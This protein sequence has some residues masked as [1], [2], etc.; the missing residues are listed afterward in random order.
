MKRVVISV[1]GSIVAPNG[2]DVSYVKKLKE[3]VLSS[4]KNFVLI[5]G[6]GK[7]SRDYVDFAREISEIKETDA[8]WI[9]IMATRINAELVRAVFGDLAYEKVIINPTETF[10]TDK[11]VVIGAGYEPGYSSDMDAV[12]MAENLDADVIINLTN[13]DYVYDKD[14]RNNTDAKPFEKMSYFEFENIFGSTFTP[15]QNAPFDPVAAIKGKEL[16]KK[17]IV[18]N[19]TDIKN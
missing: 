2:V 10:E 1:G 15:G 8:H 5:V 19:G 7:L 11:K 4:D 12:L 14:P 18:M 6:G 13:V 3:L 9:G 17:I 16:N